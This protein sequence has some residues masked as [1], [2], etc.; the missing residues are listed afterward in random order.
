MSD[1]RDAVLARVRG[2]LAGS[3]ANGAAPARDYRL[4]TGEP[5]ETLV[6]RFA[7]RVG[8]YRASVRRATREE[9]IGDA[10]GDVRGGRR[11]AARRARE[12]AR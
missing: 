4:S 1:A 9:L 7:E 8:E 6:A 12:P 3:A 2:A 10:R 5:H 11:P